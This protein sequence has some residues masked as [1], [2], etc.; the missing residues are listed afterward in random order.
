M[1][2]KGGHSAGSGW[3]CWWGHQQGKGKVTLTEV[4][5]GVRANRRYKKFNHGAF[6]DEEL[7]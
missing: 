7:D 6:A 2:E 1:N 5:V 3:S 4:Q